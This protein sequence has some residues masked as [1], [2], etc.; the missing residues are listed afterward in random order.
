VPRRIFM[1]SLL[2]ALSALS[3]GCCGRIRQC[4]ANHWRANH[5]YGLC[6]GCCTP[7]YKMAAYPGPGPAG[8]STCGDPALGA[9]VYQP[10]YAVPAG[11]PTIGNPIPLHGPTVVPSTM[12]PKN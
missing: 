2:A 10:P 12:P 1:L 9:V 7:A 4:I 5:P 8:C 6:G 11:V 3:T